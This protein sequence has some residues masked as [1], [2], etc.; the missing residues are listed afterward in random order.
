M[1][2]GNGGPRRGL[3]RSLLLEIQR[4]ILLSS[5][6]ISVGAVCMTTSCGGQVVKEADGFSRELAARSLRYFV[7]NAHP[8][9]GLVRD[10]ASNFAATPRRNRVASL[11]A[12]G[13]GFAVWATAVERGEMDRALAQSLCSRAL[14]FVE[15]K[16]FH[17]RGWLYHF[18]DWE[19]GE[20]WRDAEISTIDTALFMAGALHAAHVFKGTDVEA[21]ASRLYSRLDFHDMMTN[22][23][24]LA[25]KRTLSHGWTPEGGYLRANWDSYSELLILVLLGLGHPERPL[26]DEAWLAWRRRVPEEPGLGLGL[27]LFVHQYSHLFV[28]MRELGTEGASFFENSIA[29]TELDRLGARSDRRYLSYRE[30]LWGRSA[31]GS[32]EGYRAYSVTEHDGTVCPG[33]AGASLLFEPEIVAR[34]LEAWATGEWGERIWGRYGFSDSINLDREWFDPDALGITVGPLYL[35]LGE[36]HETAAPWRA[37]RER[38]WVRRAQVVIARAEASFVH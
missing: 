32:R 8:E 19:T 16:L 5:G 20:R 24:T 33:C 30:G 35:A 25:A 18:V 28:D 15:E 23:G 12:T 14:S 10:R 11:A 1:G 17:H 2:R 36:L 9:T 22:G 21:R 7:D 37:T 38:D 13:F 4:V 34:D 27:P 3:G 29:A 6:L 26:P 31:S